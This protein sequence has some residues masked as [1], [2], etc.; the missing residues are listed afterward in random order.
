[1]TDNSQTVASTLL[2]VT[3]SVT[4]FTA[5]LPPFSEVRKSVNEPHI[6]NDVR[7]GEV[8][9]LTLV[10]AIGV[11]ASALTH[12]PVPAA[13]SIVA[14]IALVCMYESVLSATP[15]ESGYGNLRAV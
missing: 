3:S 5:L 6:V 2:A 15:K 10:V 14:G 13:A 7:L 12:S 4:V 9:S 8:A 11:T 1:M